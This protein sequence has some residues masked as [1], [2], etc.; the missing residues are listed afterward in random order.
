MESDAVVGVFCR[1]WGVPLIDGGT[2]RLPRIVGLGRAL[3]LILTGRPVGADE[4]LAIGFANRVVAPGDGARRGRGAGR[5]A[6][7]VPAG[8]PALGPRVGLRSTRQARCRTRSASSSGTGSRC[9]PRR[10]AARPASRPARVGTARSAQRT[11][12]AERR[13][14]RSAGI[15]PGYADWL[16]KT[17]LAPTSV[18]APPVS[19][20][21][22]GLALR[23]GAVAASRGGLGGNYGYD[24][25]VYYT[26]ADAF[27]HGRMPYRDF[28]LLHP[29]GL[30]LVL[31]PFAVLGRLTTDSTGFVAGNVALAVLGAANALLVYLVARQL[32]TT[33]PAA[34]LG[35]MFYAVWYGAVYAELS[36]RLEPLGSFAFLLGMLALT[37]DRPQHLRR[38][39]VL[40]GA[41]FGFALS[42]KMWWAAPL[43]IAALWLARGADRR[44]RVPAFLAGTAATVVVV[45]GPFFTMAPT[46]MWHMV[47]TEQLGRP[48]LVPFLYRTITFS[49]LHGAIASIRGT[50]EIA[51]SVAFGVVVIALL[52]AAARLPAARLAVLIAAAQIV[53]LLTVRPSSRS[54]STTPPRRSRS[55]SPRRRT[56]PG[57]GGAT[58]SGRDRS[59]RS[60]RP[61]R[62]SPSAGCWCTRS[63]SSNGSPP[64]S[65]PTRSRT[66]AAS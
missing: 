6:G 21:A 59:R 12:V 19:V 14:T 47:V 26:A 8:L 1:R 17:S 11:A 5:R 44:R 13:P 64:T 65:L 34:R 25:S 27:V 20:F 37:R 3:D 28:V 23:L 7:R 30:M 22:V 51:A 63:A 48:S 2:V 49:T 57:S 58:A 24:P 39:T 36:I 9:S 31:A 16:I 38:D 32:G 56:P 10:C 33:R 4:A 62:A 15:Q 42:V 46:A 55:S 40:A 18:I 53:V 35:G 52:A 29:P 50:A 66:C 60:S 41:A 45:E 54:T 61:P 43:V